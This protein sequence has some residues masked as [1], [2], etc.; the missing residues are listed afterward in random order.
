M[1]PFFNKRALKAKNVV[2]N[3]K[4]SEKRIIEISK[5]YLVKD[6]SYMEKGI[7]DFAE[8]LSGQESQIKNDFENLLNRFPNKEELRKKLLDV[9]AQF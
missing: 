1:L 8:K 7:R 5:E 2:N 6:S 9:H 3:F 4:N